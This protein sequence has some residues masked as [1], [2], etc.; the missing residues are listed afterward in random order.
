MQIDMLKP[1]LINRL[2]RWLGH[3]KH[4]AR[5]PRRPAGARPTPQGRRAGPRAGA[6]RPVHGKM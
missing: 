4:R 3:D 6:G 1:V 2:R 5:R